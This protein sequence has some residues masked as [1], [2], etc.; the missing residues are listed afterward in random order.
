MLGKPL[1]SRRKFIK[2]SLA[3]AAAFTIVPRHVLGGRGFIAPSDQ[4]TKA[5]IGVGGMGSA[6]I[7]YPYF[8]LLAV[9]DV[10]ENHL[11]SALQRTGKDVTGYKDFRE[12]LERPGY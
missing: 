1:F 10:D 11:K 5:I 7:N 8:K 12:V 3:T 6:H 4:L 9:C 2:T